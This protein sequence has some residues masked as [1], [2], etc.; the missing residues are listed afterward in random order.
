MT[1]NVLWEGEVLMGG[2]A[3]VQAKARVVKQDGAWLDEIAQ[4]GPGMKLQVW[5]EKDGEWRK[6]SPYEINA[7]SLVMALVQASNCI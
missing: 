4:L 3:H 7:V 6:K 1:D 5:N 2:R